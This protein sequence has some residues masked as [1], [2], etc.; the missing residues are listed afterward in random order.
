MSLPKCHILFRFRDGP[1][2]GANQ[3]LKV[4]R[5]YF[6]KE[7]LYTENPE[8]SDVIIFNSNPYSYHEVLKDIYNLKKQNPRLIIVNRVD[9]PVWIVRGK[10]KEVD[11]A[12]FRFNSA[13]TDG[14]IFQSDWSR[15]QCY[16][17]GLKKNRFETTIINAPDPSIFNSTGKLEFSLDR[18][19]RVIA[20]SW[21]PNWKKGFAVYQWLDQNLDYDKFEVVFIGN[22]PVEFKN[23]THISP[24]TSENLAREL[25]KSDIYITASQKDPCS[26]S[27][28][29]ALHCN[30]PAI[31][32]NDGGH[33]E[34]VGDA[35]EV[36]NCAEEI[37]HLLEKIVSSYESYQSS[38]RIPAIDRVGAMYAS[39]IQGICEQV[40]EGTYK[41]K[42]FFK[43]DYLIILAR[44]WLQP[45]IALK[46]KK[47]ISSLC[48][49]LSRQD[50]SV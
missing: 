43:I 22:S 30:L 12:I 8:E 23:I 38:I 27:I 37:P 1:W 16:A 34:I 31:A 44:V 14:T 6:R 47:A 41:P 46:L 13:V 24:Q 11:R 32:L 15:K 39:F 7:G 9:G 21:S 2:G 18:K 35:G 20:S 40:R 25:K 33:P 19:V 45:L 50:K 17:M 28:I 49:W 36:F 48:P 42:K 4:L 26:N 3:F 5:E 29:E 10:N